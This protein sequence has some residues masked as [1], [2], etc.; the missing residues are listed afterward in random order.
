MTTAPL[1]YT[2]S[3]PDA[4]VTGDPVAYFWASMATGSPPRQFLRRVCS[5]GEPERTLLRRQCHLGL[6]EGSGVRDCKR[7]H[8]WS[9]EGHGS[10]FNAG[11]FVYK[12]STTFSG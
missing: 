4:G 6:P 10:Q 3:Y 12:A 8:R 11:S 7:E 5:G 1:W 2:Y 9:L